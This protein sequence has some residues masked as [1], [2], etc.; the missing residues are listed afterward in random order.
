MPSTSD[1]KGL[2]TGVAGVQKLIGSK[3]MEKLVK[4]MRVASQLNTSN[5]V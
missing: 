4:D 5:T 2:W 3:A 1:G